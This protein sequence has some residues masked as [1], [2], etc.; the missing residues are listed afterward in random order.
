MQ[1]RDSWHTENSQ[2]SKRMEYL[3]RQRITG[4]LFFFAVQSSQE[5][6]THWSRHMRGSVDSQ[7]PIDGRE[8]KGLHPHKRPEFALSYLH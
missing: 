8:K 4:E 7:L 6:T 2:T 5:C 3:V 1:V